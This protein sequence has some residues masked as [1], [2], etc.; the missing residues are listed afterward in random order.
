MAQSAKDL[1][2]RDMA[3]EPWKR[4]PAWRRVPATAENEAAVSGG[5]SAKAAV[6]EQIAHPAAVRLNR[7]AGTAAL[8][9]RRFWRGKK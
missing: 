1:F 2:K 6:W 3:M 7:A 5:Y 9:T 8:A 4:Q